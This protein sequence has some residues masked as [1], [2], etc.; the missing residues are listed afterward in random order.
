MARLS[1]SSLSALSLSAVSVIALAVVMLL[2]DMPLDHAPLQRHARKAATQPLPERAS[3]LPDDPRLAEITVRFRQAVM[4]LH[5]R[6]YEEAAVALH[7]V[8]ALSPRLTDAHV[9]MGFALLGLKRY[10]EAE[11]FFRNAIDLD[12]YQGNAYWGLAEVFEQRG[13]LPAALGAMRTYIHL[14]PP[15]DPYV[16]RAR[17]AL[18]EWDS[19]LSRGPLSPEEARWIEEEGQRWEDRNSPGRDAPAGRGREIPL[20]PMP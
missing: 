1:S 11:A 17:A 5:A 7:R 16:R 18:W 8:L 4:M 9:N 15:G 14:A 2:L 20:R 13:D 12:P 3:P 19:R 10:R 6:R